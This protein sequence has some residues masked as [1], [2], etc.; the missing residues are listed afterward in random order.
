MNARTRTA[1]LGLFAVM[2]WVGAGQVRALPETTT[3]AAGPRALLDASL[4]TD[5]EGGAT[6]VLTGDAALTYYAFTLEDPPRVVLDVLG[7]PGP[8]PVHLSQPSAFLRRVRCGVRSGRDGQPLARYVVETGEPASYRVE[9]EGAQLRLT[10]APNQAPAAADVSVPTE[11]VETLTPEPEAAAITEA[12][13]AAVEAPAAAVAESSAPEEPAPP[14]EDA[15]AQPAGEQRVTPDLPTQ[16]A[17]PMDPPLEELPAMSLDVQGADL[18]TVFRSISEYAGANIV[19]DSNVKGT[20]TIRALD[21]PWREMLEAVCRA[22]G[23]AAIETGPVIRIATLRTAQE[24][25]LAQESIA[26]KQE[27]VMPLQT[28]IV[29]VSYANAGELQETLTKVCSSRGQVQVDARTNALIVTDIA[30]RIEQLEEMVRRLDGETIQVEIAARIVDVDES[31]ARQLGINWA[32]ENL[33]SESANATGSVTVDANDVVGAPGEVRVGIIRSFGEIQARLQV[34]EKKN[35]AEIISAPRITTVDNRMARILVGKEV[36]LITLDFSGNAITEL[37]KVGIALEVT[38]HVNNDSQITMD[39][40][41]EISDLSSQSTAQGGVVFTTTE[42]DT[43]VLVA[44]GQTAVIGGLIRGGEVLYE[45]GV[46]FL[47]DIPL[48]GALFKT[49]DRRLEKRDLLIFVTPRIVRAT[50]AAVAA[51]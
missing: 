18:N 7:V 19:A 8:I 22:S 38:P 47:K 25:A 43:R 46:P 13:P 44:D 29:Q 4:A 3:P 31:E 23:L 39:L 14:G 10:V 51:P 33:H 27:E 15:Q 1:A 26:R 49:S 5:A 16:D 48:L 40:H 37:K 6:L 50:D 20:V 28:R 36:P 17:A 45:R 41:P 12:P 2:L 24:E 34:L 42:A 30:P 35:Q 11:A 21:L 32:G 9:T